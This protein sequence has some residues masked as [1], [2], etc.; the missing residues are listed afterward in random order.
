M[1]LSSVYGQ[2]EDYPNAL[3]VMQLAHSADGREPRRHQAG[4]LLQSAQHR[5][6]LPLV[7]YGQVRQLAQ[8]GRHVAGRA[9]AI[10]GHHPQQSQPLRTLRS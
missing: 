1:Q 3:A 6:P 7:G 2:M 4:D 5:R 10:V 8:G 9:Y